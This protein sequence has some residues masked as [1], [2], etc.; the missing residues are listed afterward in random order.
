VSPYV[1]NAGTYLVSVV[2]GIFVL[3]VMLR[4]LLQLVRADFYNPVSQAIVTLT[5]P[6]LRPLRRIIPGLR[7]LDV[8]ALALA[9]A[10]QGLE[11]WLIFALQ[12]RGGVNPAGLLVLSIGE[13]ANLVCW[14]FIIA[15]IAQIVLSWVAPGAYNPVTQLLY[16]LT[17]PLM[18]P[19]RRLLPPLSGIDFSP[20]VPLV[21]L[22]LTQMLLIAPV[23]DL[24]AGLLH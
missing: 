22:R 14:I 20:I 3:A 24:G 7:G 9:L 1:S 11:L 2:F 13:L 21:L 5:S 12:G 16:S 4:F 6:A 18:D 17:R 15:I 19:A 10:L 23:R 8:P